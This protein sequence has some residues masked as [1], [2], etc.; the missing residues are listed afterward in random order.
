M[1]KGSCVALV[2]PFKNGRVDTPKL[3]DLVEF[4]IENGTSAIVPCGSTGE[5]ATLTHSEH[6]RVVEI[7]V[8]S[9]RGRV[10][11]IAGTG[12]NSTA[13][14]ISLTRHAKQAG[15]DGALIIIP[16]YNRPTQDGIAEHFY[17]VAKAVPIPIIVYNIP[18]RTGTNLLPS[19]L[20]RIA[21]RSK[22]IVGIKESSGDLEQI[23]E[24]TRAFTGKK[25]SLYCGDD[26]LTPP[27][28]S[29]G[30]KGVI[31]VLANIAPRD[32][33]ELCNSVMQGDP[34]RARALH[35]KMSPL[36]K[37]LFIETNPGPIKTA[38]AFLGMCSAEMRLP[39]FH[40]R[41]E[42]KAKLIRAIKAYGLK[43]S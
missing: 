3:R 9:A 38:M 32:V 29:I 16:Y 7:V 30:G 21:E 20:F 27:V 2:T 6:H 15:A 19:T 12:S 33:Q 35:L 18:S 42:N 4:Q 13:E 14:T 10:P 8:K 23:S 43:R 37:A 40:M 26:S 11:I 24:I 28:L 34:D 22:N 41:A 17:Q 39:L 5:S 31:S 1:F 36:V 25:F